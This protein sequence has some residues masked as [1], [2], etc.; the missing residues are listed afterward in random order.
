[1]FCQRNE[2]RDSEVAAKR[3]DTD[4]PVL[5]QYSLGSVKGRLQT[6]TLFSPT[7]FESAQSTVL[8]PRH[9]HVRSW[10]ALLG[11]VTTSDLSPQ[12]GPS[13]NKAGDFR[14]LPVRVINFEQI[15]A[16]DWHRL[17]SMEVTT[18][19]FYSQEAADEKG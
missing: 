5:S 7:D 13:S 14:Q 8:P 18:K 6:G 10:Q 9:Q 15:A 3:K 2:S 4:N 16:V 19:E 17:R 11:H 1:V 12:S